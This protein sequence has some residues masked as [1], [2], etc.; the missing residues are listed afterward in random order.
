MVSVSGSSQKQEIIFVDNGSSESISGTATSTLPRV[1]VKGSRAASPKKPDCN[2]NPMGKKPVI[3][4][5]GEKYKAEVDYKTA[6]LYDLGLVRTYRSQNKTGS[7][8]GAYWPS[9]YD[10]G[11]TVSASGAGCTYMEN[12]NTC[13]PAYVTV[14]LP[15][16]TPV[17]YYWNGDMVFVPNY[18]QSG[19]YGD[20]LQW[21]QAE[22]KHWLIK[23]RLIYKFYKGS[24]ISIE[25]L[26]GKVLRQYTLS[27]IP[28]QHVNKITDAAG[29]SV[30]LEWQ[31][32]G[33]SARMVRLTDPMGR[34][35]T[36]DYNSNG[37]LERVTSPGANPDIRLYHYENTANAALLTGISVNGVRQTRYSYYADGRVQKSGSENDEEFDQ[38]TYQT[39]ST[40]VVDAAGQSTTY[41]YVGTGEDRKLA[42]VSRLP[43][44]SCGAAVAT[45]VYDA[46]G[47]IDYTEDWN[48]VRTDYTFVVDYYSRDSMLMDMTTAKGKSTEL[49]AEYKW[50]SLTFRPAISEILYR[51]ADGAPNLRVNY[52]FHPPVV[53]GTVGDVGGQWEEKSGRL[54][55]ITKTDLLGGAERRELHD[56][57]FHTNL[58]LAS[59]SQTIQTS[60]GNKTTVYQYDALGNLIAIVNPLGQQ[61]TWSNF[62]AFGRPG[63]FIDLNGIIT[64]YVYSQNGNLVSETKLLSTGNRTITSTYDN[65]HQLTS[66][67]APGGYSA[68]Y[69]YNSSG[70]MTA[71]GNSQNEYITSTLNP[72]QSISSFTSDRHIPGVNGTSP[73]VASVATFVDSA[74]RDSLGRLWKRTG[75][76]GQTFTNAY[77]NNGNLKS[78]TDALG[79]SEQ[80]DYDDQNRVIR[81]TSPDGGAITYTY[82]KYGNL[83]TVTDPRGLTTQYAYNGFGE[84][85]SQTSPDTGSTTYEY[86]EAGF[87]KSQIQ[88]DGQIVAFAWDRTGRMLSQNAG[89]VAQ[90]FVYDEGVYGKGHLTR[91][92]DATGQTAFQYNAAG[93]LVTQINTISGQSFTTTWGYDAA[94]RTSTVTYPTGISLN[95]SY[96]A[97]GRLTG[98]TGNHSGVFSTIADSFLYQPATDRRYAWRFGNGLPKLITLDA[99]SRTSQISSASAMNIGFDYS[100]D[101]TIWR[102]TDYVYANQTSNISYDPNRRVTA[103]SSSLSQSF[104][105]DNVGNR[106]G[107]TTAAGYLGHNLAGD[108]NRLLSVSGANWRNFNYNIS[109]NVV[110]ENRWD[111]SRTYGYDAL[112]RLSSATV[113]GSLN[114]YFLNAFNQRAA[115]QNNSGLTRYVYGPDGELLAEIGPNSTSYI[116]LDGALLGLVRNGQ[117]YAS[118]ND[119]LG[120][121]EVITNQAAQVV[122][123]SF[124]T[125][126]DR[127]IL[128]DSIGGVNVGYPG[129]YW[130]Q[131]TGL[132]YNWHRYYDAQLGRY[133][134]SDPIGIAGGVNTYAYVEGN[135]L[136]SYDPYGLFGMDDVWGAIYNRTGFEISQ[137][138]VDAWA[139]FGDGVS[140]NISKRIREGQGIG[141]V[142]PCSSYYRNADFVGSVMAPIGRFAYV[143]R[144][145]KIGANG[146]KNVAQAIA[147][148]AERNGVKKYFRGPLS[149]IFTDYKS[150]EWAAKRFAER[151]AEAFA[152]SVGKSNYGF[153]SLAAFGFLK[154][155]QDRFLSDGD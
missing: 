124:N 22:Q 69:Q 107:Q 143:A 68:K 82:D 59:H 7:T 40:T 83:A 130:D 61:I 76:N 133:I 13:Y 65:L 71:L 12:S 98:I 23:D 20:E 153:N 150:A 89:L 17:V 92:T 60:S 37:M 147:A 44:Q 53:S 102:I 118:H 1:S 108:S 18:G 51:A 21:S 19:T 135:P 111:G 35:W 86:D 58:S 64:E 96:D 72:T 74:Q 41:T 28:S 105:W 88:P 123:R 104:A 75:N 4:S 146:V 66:I 137:E 126:F 77:D 43:T 132:W 67:A 131:E 103:T 125:A 24:L 26:S 31:G 91:L 134:Q 5:T 101:N 139:G 149:R 15:G 79:R 81:R 56:Y 47:N 16:E 3:Y 45:T 115:K 42:S 29:R 121:P 99:D 117:F 122:W 33:A 90:T 119:H 145:G 112:G 120:R 114:T 87:L 49:K 46:N 80:L 8:F 2:T 27:G 141:G 10:M 38:L 52:N 154:A 32:T 138:A 95:Y 48:G 144:V 62:D 152:A 113:D 84:M 127:Q 116:W 36:Y 128:V 54:A 97:N 106:I 151:G 109:G 129:Q 25:D 136:S 73:T 110:G 63:R 34:I 94:G 70:R 78:V 6:G 55:S 155:S 142:D 93:Q 9:S 148:S 50:D 39:N 11:T 85:T 100:S 57:T 30:N 14:T 140:F